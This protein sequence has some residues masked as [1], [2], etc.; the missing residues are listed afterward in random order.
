MANLFL[1]LVFPC[2]ISN[3]ENIINKTYKGSPNEIPVIE[4]QKDKTPFSAR[5]HSIYKSIKGH[6]DS[7]LN[8]EVNE[9][10]LE[11]KNNGNEDHR[12]STAIISSTIIHAL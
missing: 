7:C 3:Q 11:V 1:L 6:T 12:K 10:H 4:N 2:L 8:G 9:D 5:A